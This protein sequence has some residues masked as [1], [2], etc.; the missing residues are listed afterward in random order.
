MLAAE[1]RTALVIAWLVVS[2]ALSPLLL[3][4]FVLP[5]EAL[6]SLSPQCEARLQGRSCAFCGMTTAFVAIGEGRLQDAVRAHRAGLP[7]FA[8]L[9]WNQCVALW[10]VVTRVQAAGVPATI[11]LILRT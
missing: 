1:F 8:A 6:H 11:R 5:A 10:F 2:A 3:A 4:I 7:L 9:V